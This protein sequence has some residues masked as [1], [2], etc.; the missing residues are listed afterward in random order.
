MASVEI[1]LNML[2]PTYAIGGII[3]E[4]KVPILE[5]RGHTLR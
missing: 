5:R 3:H 4:C 1:N 2:S